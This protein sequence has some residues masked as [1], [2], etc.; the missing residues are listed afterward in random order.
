MPA[1]VIE[2][3]NMMKKVLNMTPNLPKP[4]VITC[5]YVVRV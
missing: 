5:A 1:P 2:A 4:I 3:E